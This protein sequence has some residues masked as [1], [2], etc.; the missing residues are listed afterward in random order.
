M[1][2]R[3]DTWSTRKL[4]TLRAGRWIRY[5]Y[6]VKRELTTAVHHKTTAVHHFC[7]GISRRQCI[8]TFEAMSHL[9]GSLYASHE[10]PSASCVQHNFQR[11]YVWTSCFSETTSAG[12]ISRSNSEKRKAKTKD[13]DDVFEA[14]SVLCARNV[15]RR[16]SVGIP[17]SATSA[18]FRSGEITNSEVFRKYN[19][20]CARSVTTTCSVKSLATL[21]AKGTHPG[22][23]SV[24]NNRIKACV[25]PEARIRLGLGVVDFVP[26]F[27]LLH[28]SLKTL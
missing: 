22:S 9:S 25:N 7:G 28:M 8:T 17:E 19:E 3:V 6:K 15:S 27:G 10:L 16:R 4:N 11:R 2:R 13:A 12:Q 24:S 20:L 18:D 1:R 23:P 5:G 14:Y 21:H 26:K